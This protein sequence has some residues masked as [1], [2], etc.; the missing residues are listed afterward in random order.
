MTHPMRVLATFDDEVHQTIVVLHD[1]VE[2]SNGQV[3]I[4]SLRRLGVPAVEALPH[5]SDEPRPD[6]LTRLKRTP[7]PW[8]SSEPTSVNCDGHGSRGSI[9]HGRTRPSQVRRPAFLVSGPELRPPLAAAPNSLVSLLLAQ[10]I[11]VVLPEFATYQGGRS[12]A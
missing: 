5:P 7:N 11:V 1:A 3:T 2:D 10:P 6:Y 9:L 8:P 12:P 4:E